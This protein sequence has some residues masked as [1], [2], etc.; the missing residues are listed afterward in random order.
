LP[1]LE[2]VPCTINVRASV[3]YNTWR[4]ASIKRA[5][6]APGRAAMR[7]I[8]GKPKDAQPRIMTW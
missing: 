7:T 8:S 4:K 1:T 2:A 3:I 6:S 5:R